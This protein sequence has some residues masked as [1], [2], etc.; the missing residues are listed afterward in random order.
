MSA[1]RWPLAWLLV[2][3]LAALAG[4]AGP[5]SRSALDTRADLVRQSMRERRLDLRPHWSL[6]G[7][8][9][10]RAGKEGG[11]GSLRW[12][13]IGPE[14]MQ[15]HLFAPVSGQGWRLSVDAEGARL[16]G[17]EGGPQQAADPDRL[18]REAVGWEVPIALLA[19]WVRGQRGSA[20]A[21]IE[22][23]AEGRPATLYEAGWRI[24]YRGWELS[25]DPPLPRRVEAS[26]GQ[27]RLRLLVQ[28][29]QVG[30]HD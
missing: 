17:L 20:Q 12:E 1:G 16:E 4:C 6:Q 2:G 14:H 9:A 21:R 23:D 11:S 8:V 15:L 13:R 22:F 18:L 28:R 5:Q 24:D 10:V 27:H 30:D 3:L 29:W 26:S 7:R 25:Q 19:R